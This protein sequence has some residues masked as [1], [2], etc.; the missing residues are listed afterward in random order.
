MRLDQSVAFLCFDSSAGALSIEQLK[1]IALGLERSEVRFLWVVKNQLS[2]S[3]DLDLVLP[4][5][6]LERT[7]RRERG[8]VV[9]SWAPTCKIL[10]HKP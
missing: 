3:D 2:K 7:P 6:L 8:K 4:R 1:Q 5:G 10:G 9:K